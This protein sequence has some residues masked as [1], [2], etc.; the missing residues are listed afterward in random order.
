MRKLN[1]RGAQRTS[2]RY[3][4]EPSVSASFYKIAFCATSTSSVP[5]VKTS[6]PLCVKS[7]A[8]ITVAASLFL[9]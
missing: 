6:V 3:T 8:L 4:K 2:Q 1:H 9:K 7:E 5:S